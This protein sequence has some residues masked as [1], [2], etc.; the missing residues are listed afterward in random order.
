M[1]PD[2]LFND[3]ASERLLLAMYNAHHQCMFGVT[4]FEPVSLPNDFVCFSG[5]EFI[6][7]GQKE[8]EDLFQQQGKG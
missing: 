5:I 3:P 1:N 6:F 8:P 4:D 7:K 2:L